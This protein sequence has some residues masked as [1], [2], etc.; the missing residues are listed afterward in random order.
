MIVKKIPVGMLL[1]NCYL[2]CDE[3]TKEAI[4]IDPGSKPE[5]ILEQIAELGCTVKYI[6]FTHGHYDHIVAAHYIQEPTGALIAMHQGD[7]SWLAADVVASR[8]RYTT[9]GYVEVKPDILLDDGDVLKVGNL[10]FKVL[11]TPGHS[12][13]CICLVCEDYIF[14]GDT[15][16]KGQCGRC[17]LTGGDFQ[18]MLVSLKKISELPGDYHVCPGHEYSTTLDEERKN[19]P[20]IAQALAQ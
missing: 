2:V 15:L 11:S 5:K 14:T 10:E 12:S 17:D 4:V 16:F 19:N 1:T 7:S 3:Q 6:V 13:G 20:Y 18:S 8:G 9:A